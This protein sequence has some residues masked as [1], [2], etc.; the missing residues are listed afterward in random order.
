MLFPVDAEGDSALPHDWTSVIWPSAGDAFSAG[1]SAAAQST[2]P[3]SGPIQ[4]SYQRKP[5]GTEN[6]GGTED[7][8]TIPSVRDR[9]WRTYLFRPPSSSAL[10]FARSLEVTGQSREFVFLGIEVGHRKLENL[11]LP[12]QGLQIYPSSIHGEVMLIDVTG[13]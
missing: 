5:A 3:R 8:G 13:F 11:R 1:A 6:Q 10:A 12:L 4:L 2:C 7:G 9:L